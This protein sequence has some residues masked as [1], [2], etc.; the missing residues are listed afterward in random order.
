M[1]RQIP[2]LDLSGLSSGGSTARL[3]LAAQLREAC[4]AHGFFYISGH[5]VPADLLEDVLSQV[6][7]LFALPHAD[8]LVIA[9]TDP[10]VERGWEPLGSQVLEPGASPD[11]KE[12]FGIG[13]TGDPDWPNLWPA[14]L[15]A[16]EP[17]LMRYFASCHEQA[18]ELMELLALSLDLP[19]T[20]FDAFCT[21]PLC[22]LRALQ[23][24]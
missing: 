19:E 7:L 8:K 23:V 11:L 12:A 14:A 16:L 10:L 2:V 17:L 3:A 6:R 15:P 20:H 22:G 18:V 9:R 5:R 21:S 1:N 24:A 4:T 13:P